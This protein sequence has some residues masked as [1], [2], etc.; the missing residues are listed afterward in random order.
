MNKPDPD[1]IQEDKDRKSSAAPPPPLND[2]QHSTLNSQLPSTVTIL[3]IDDDPNDSALLKAAA[4]KAGVKFTIQSTVD[5]DDAVAYLSGKGRYADRAQYQKPRLLLLDM[6]MP[7]ATGI[8]VLGW[9][10]SQ[11]D[12]KEVPVVVLSGSEMKDDKKRALGAGA[13]CYMVKPLG[14]DALVNLVKEIEQRWLLA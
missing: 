7:R 14:F 12:L 8:D 2:S 10:R 3:H 4:A 13:N 11:P 6:K 1:P 5:G 9:I